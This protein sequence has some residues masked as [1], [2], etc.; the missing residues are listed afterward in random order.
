MRM[1]C[2]SA[3]LDVVPTA[4]AQRRDPAELL[5]VL[6]AEEITC[7]DRPSPASH[8]NSRPGL[9]GIGADSRG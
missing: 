6:L 4:R 9:A 7:R 2:A 5:R 8:A 1:P 3:A